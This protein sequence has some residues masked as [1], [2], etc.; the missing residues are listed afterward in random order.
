VPIFVDTGAWFAISV[1]S[2]P[3]H[4]A[5]VAFMRSNS[6]RLVTS[7]YVYDELLTLFRSRGQLDR[8]KEWVDQVQQSRLDILRISEED[9]Q[10]AT[11]VFFKFADKSWSFTDCTSRA[12]MQRLGIQ[13]AFLFDDHFRQFGTIAVVP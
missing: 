2:D 4:G 5:A 8:A 13:S 11:D 6:D 12:L 9:V 10:A 3:D 7:D 1:P